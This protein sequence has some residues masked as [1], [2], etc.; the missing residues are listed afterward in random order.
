MATVGNR[1]GDTKIILSLKA[2]DE[3]PS[4]IDYDLTVSAGKGHEEITF[5]STHDIEGLSFENENVPEVP[6]ILNSLNLLTESKISN[7]LF[8]PRD[9][10]DFCLE[11]I[12]ENQFFYGDFYRVSLF[13]RSATIHKNLHWRK[14]SMPGIQIEVSKEDL[15]S[16]TNE[17]RKEYE[18]LMSEFKQ[19]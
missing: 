3:S 14:D 4:W 8:E 11:V 9:E 12:H 16:F 17:L 2:T 1:A 15:M 6:A 5:L 7:Y 10:K 19:K 13:I 18:E